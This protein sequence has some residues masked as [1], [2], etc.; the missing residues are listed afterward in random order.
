MLSAYVL[1]KNEILFL[2][3]FFWLGFT[4]CKAAQPRTAATLQK[5][6]ST[7]TLEHKDE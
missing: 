4:P 3:I 1:L 6:R 7:K 2:D 5:K